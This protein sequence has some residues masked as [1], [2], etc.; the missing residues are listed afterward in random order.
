MRVV[1]AGVFAGIRGRVGL[2]PASHGLGCWTPTLSRGERSNSFLY[3]SAL[4]GNN[5]CYNNPPDFDVIR[6][7][8]PGGD[9]FPVGR[10]G[11]GPRT[12]RLVSHGIVVPEVARS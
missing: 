11:G 4:A 7:K 10:S 6:I 9:S 12:C 8:S 5:V 1:L 2:T 3:A